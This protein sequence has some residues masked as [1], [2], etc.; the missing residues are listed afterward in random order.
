M[1]NLFCRRDE[2]LQYQDEV[3]AYSKFKSHGY[4]TPHPG[5]G[6]INRFKR[7]VGISLY[8]DFTLTHLPEA[9]DK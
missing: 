8:T 9:W 1:S 3:D 6:K 4:F 2:N 5:I 7:G